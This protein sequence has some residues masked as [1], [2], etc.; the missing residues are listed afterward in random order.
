[1]SSLQLALLCHFVTSPPQGGRVFTATSQINPLTKNALLL[2]SHGGRQLLHSPP[3]WGRCHEV[4][5]GGIAEH[6][7]NSCCFGGYL[8]QR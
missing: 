5:E 6:E 2:I 3:L 8:A 4:T 1:M 7:Y